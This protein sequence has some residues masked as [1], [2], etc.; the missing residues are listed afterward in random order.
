MTD[1]SDIS[2]QEFLPKRPTRRTC[3]FGEVVQSWDALLEERDDRSRYSY[4]S[5]MRR[6]VRLFGHMPV[7]AL[8]PDVVEAFIG[9]SEHQERAP[10]TIRRDL[11][12]LSLLCQHAQEI[13]AGDQNPVSLVP[14][15]KIP[16]KRVVDPNRAR[17][18][19]LRPDEVEALISDPRIPFW[20]RLYWALLL[21]TGA[22]PGEAS[23]LRLSDLTR[24]K[25]LPCAVIGRAWHSKSRRIE[26]TKTEFI[27]YIPVHPRL[28]A[29]LEERSQHADTRDGLAAPRCLPRTGGRRKIFDQREAL[30]DW[31]SDLR[32]LGI[33]DPPSGPRRLYATRHTFVT[34]ALKGGA[35]LRAIEQITHTSLSER[36]G[37][38]VLHYAH[39]LG[40]P[41]LCAAVRKLPVKEAA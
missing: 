1:D 5:V 3:L 8:T 41:E 26:P 7:L 16:R 34:L 39:D 28:A 13:G 20:R 37:S 27:R 35:D 32:V 17:L 33:P 6:L 18:E 40:W 25:P 21:L 23:A 2:W 19:V 30:D 24:A 15:R 31:K 4:R 29:L 12:V 9:H 36:R 10:N 11:Y 14:R 38:S 22:R